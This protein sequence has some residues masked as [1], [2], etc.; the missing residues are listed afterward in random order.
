MGISATR[1]T[2]AIGA[3]V[4]G[5][6]LGPD[7]DDADV[8]AIRGALLEHKVL[9]FRGQTLDPATLT[10]LAT[11]FGD[12][13][14]AHPVEPAVEGHP[15]VLALDSEE[16]ARADV[17]HS[18]L[19]FQECPPLGA[20][21][22]AEVVPEV[23][24]DT[25]WVDMNAAYDALSPALRTFLDGLTATH[26]PFKA[27]DYF[28]ARDASGDKAA[29]TAALRPVSHPVVRVHPETGRRSLFVNPLFTLKIDGLRRVESDALLELIQSVATRPDA[30]VRWRWLAGDVA[31]WD[32]RCTMH[33][34]LMDYGQARRKMVRVALEG[35]RPVGVGAA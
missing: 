25:V 5:V 13:T 3:E 22:H 27:G 1:V 9:F 32:N 15:E 11:R 30:M 31:F 10:A 34:A 8:V 21:L 18:D 29:T 24:G 17:W 23:G 35:D 33:Y 12:P 28:A 4:G 14:P 26:S 7:L 16:G 6:R 2:P 19:T 20:M